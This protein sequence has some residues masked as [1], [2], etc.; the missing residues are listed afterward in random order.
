M[1]AVPHD[2][3]NRDVAR[4]LSEHRRR[5]PL[6]IYA[7]ALVGALL[8]AGHWLSILLESPGDTIRSEL[9]AAAAEMGA[10]LVLKPG[11]GV[12]AA[13]RRDFSGQDVS[14][15]TIPTSSTIAV[16]LYGVDRETCV[17]AATKAR[18]IEVDGPVV[19]MLQGY[20]APEE[21]RGRNTMTWW[22]M[23]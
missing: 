1:T 8:L 20:G 9:E 10:Q 11:P 22:I 15:A 17:E 18:R 5:V 16:T 14:I 3:W 2:R 4:T 19:V 6:T 7:L 13:M 23:P 21:C 12:L